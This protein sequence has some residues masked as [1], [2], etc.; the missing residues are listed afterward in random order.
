MVV[1]TR[2]RLD[3]YGCV[4]SSISTDLVVRGDKY[5]MSALLDSFCPSLSVS[6]WLSLCAQI[7]SQSASVQFPVRARLAELSA[8]RRIPARSGGLQQGAGQG[9]TEA[10]RPQ[11]RVRLVFF[12]RFYSH[13]MT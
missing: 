12:P 2:P 8:G 1:Q 4:G 10:S 5:V 13:E 6:L 9:A 7:R 11:V 3:L